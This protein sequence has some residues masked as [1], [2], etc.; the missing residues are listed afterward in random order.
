MPGIV[1]SS[2][3]DAALRIEQGFQ[4]VTIMNDLGMFKKQSQLQIDKVRELCRQI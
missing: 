3:E 1:T 4:V 2:P